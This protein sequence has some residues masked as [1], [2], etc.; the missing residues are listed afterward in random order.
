LTCFRDYFANG[1]NLEADLNSNNPVGFGER[2]AVA[3]AVSQ[4]F[5]EVSER[6]ERT[7]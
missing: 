1:A 7:L 3:V 2:A 5:E 4:L 6:R